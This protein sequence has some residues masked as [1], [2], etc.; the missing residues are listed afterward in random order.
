MY[1]RIQKN[2]KPR[3]CGYCARIAL[4]RRFG[5]NTTWY[6]H[7][8]ALCF[9]LPTDCI[10]RLFGTTWVVHEWQALQ[11][12]PE[13]VNSGDA[14]EVP[15]SFVFSLPELMCDHSISTVQNSLFGRGLKSARPPRL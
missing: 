2:G 8:N 11:Q 13:H 14:L 1:G 9:R 7:S 3:F 15:E 4:R 12:L 5:V 10:A 6:L